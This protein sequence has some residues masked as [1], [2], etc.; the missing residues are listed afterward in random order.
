MQLEHGHKQGSK[1]LKICHLNSYH[2][3]SPHINTNQHTLTLFFLAVSFPRLACF[4]SL[5]SYC[6]GKFPCSLFTYWTIY[7]VFS[8]TR[9]NLKHVIITFIVKKEHQ[10]SWLTPK[11]F[12]ISLRWSINHQYLFSPSQIFSQMLFWGS[13]DSMGKVGSKTFQRFNISVSHV[14]GWLLQRISQFLE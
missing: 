10:Y 11:C 5:I 2:H 7:Q 14:M 6:G 1:K 4:S 12:E 9:N 13:I 3:I 8:P